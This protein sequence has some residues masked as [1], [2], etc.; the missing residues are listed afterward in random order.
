MYSANPVDEY[1][2]IERNISQLTRGR[3]SSVSGQ[4]TAPLSSARTEYLRNFKSLEDLFKGYGALMYH[5]RHHTVTTEAISCNM[6]TARV[7]GYFKDHS[8]TAVPSDSEAD[9]DAIQDLLDTQRDPLD[10]PGTTTTSASLN[11]ARPD[12]AVLLVRTRAFCNSLDATRQAIFTAVEALLPLQLAA[13]FQYN[14]QQETI[15]QHCERGVGQQANRH[16][17]RLA[18]PSWPFL[19]QAAYVLQLQGLQRSSRGKNAIDFTELTWRFTPL[20]PK[21]HESLAAT[22]RGPPQLGIP[23]PCPPV[24]VSLHKHDP[25]SGSIALLAESSAI[26]ITAAVYHVLCDAAVKLQVDVT[27]VHRLFGNFR[28]MA[29]TLPRR[30]L[31]RECVK[32]LFELFFSNGETAES[33]VNSTT[34]DTQ[35]T[36]SAEETTGGWAGTVVLSLCP[37]M[38]PVP[39]CAVVGTPSKRDAQ[40]SV[41]HRAGK[42]CFAFVL[43]GM[44]TGTT[45]D[46]SW[47]QAASAIMATPT[48]EDWRWFTYTPLRQ[49]VDE[50]IFTAI[51][52]TQE[53]QRALG[54][55]IVPTGPGGAAGII[56]PASKPSGDAVAAATPLPVGAREEFEAPPYIPGVGSW[57]RHA[58]EAL[59]TA[60]KHVTTLRVNWSIP[61]TA[62]PSGDAV[63]DLCYHPPTPVTLVISAVNHDGAPSILAESSATPL[64]AAVFE[65]LCGTAA[66]L[67]LKRGDLIITQLFDQFSRAVTA[68][69]RRNLPREFVKDVVELFF[70]ASRPDGTYAPVSVVTVDSPVNTSWVCIATLKFGN[71]APAIPLGSATA[72]SKREALAMVMHTVGKVH[73]GFVWSALASGSPPVAGG[74]RRP[75]GAMAWREAAEMILHAQ[76]AS[77]SRWDCLQEAL[78]SGRGADCLLRQQSTASFHTIA[79]TTS[80]VGLGDGLACGAT[81]AVAAPERVESIQRETPGSGVS[82]TLAT[83]GTA[84]S[85]RVL[86]TSSTLTLSSRSVR[87]QPRGVATVG[88]TTEKQ[89]EGEEQKV[90][91][92]L[93]PVRQCADELGVGQLCHAWYHAVYFPNSVS[94]GGLEHPSKAEGHMAPMHLWKLYIVPQSMCC[95]D[96]SPPEGKPLIRR[97]DWWEA[98][99]RARSSTNA[100][101]KAAQRLRERMMH[102]SELIGIPI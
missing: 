56:P 8:G 26:P 49:G 29:M 69:P 41:M 31:P 100:L 71:V 66:A 51:T 13:F 30:N 54:S 12:V 62:S 88:S 75:N 82:T 85:R 81:P 6:W 35:V 27:V 97:K 76:V 23:V 22:D 94:F 72:S 70:G 17:Y 43:T 64:A 90:R 84:G 73:M 42:E 37:N 86:N 67:Q 53:T 20:A 65:A 11:G 55:A 68:L 4:H 34:L 25:H 96:G 102:T 47:V 60:A 93:E 7:T 10:A 101:D 21:S 59:C 91:R 44:G 46:Q 99:G 14:P 28:E 79:A 19:R 50:S 95:S 58:L 5:M 38:D 2:T 61:V 63:P 48:V 52:S 40:S 98:T 33:A 57:L 16:L 83:A 92:I 89:H 3:D 87:R 39:I 74:Q 80:S 32:D 9:D 45:T 78:A 18:S 36:Q 1:L 24:L 15:Y 77:T